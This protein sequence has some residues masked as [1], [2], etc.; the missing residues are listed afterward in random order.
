MFRFGRALTICQASALI[1]AT[2]LISS[3]LALAQFAQQ[4]PKLNSDLLT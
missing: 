4:G 1:L 3:Q 2:L